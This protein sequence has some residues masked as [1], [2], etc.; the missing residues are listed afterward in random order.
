MR[1]TIKALIMTYG[2]HHVHIKTHDPKSVADWFGN[3]FGFE[4]VI[5]AERASGDRII[6]CALGANQP[7]FIVITSPVPGQDLPEGRT[8][9]SLGLEHF[10]LTTDDVPAAADRL[11]ELGAVLVDGPT[12]APDGTVMAFLTVPGDV[13]IELVHFPTGV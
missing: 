13:R 3:A 12:T 10:A 9:Q 7:P 8:H 6:R 11:V 5:D 4:I 1:S 2:F